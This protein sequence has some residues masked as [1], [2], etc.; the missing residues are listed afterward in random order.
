V[1]DVGET[2]DA[3]VR[4]LLAATGGFAPR[5]ADAGDVLLTVDG[6]PFQPRPIDPHLAAGSLAWL[7]DV[8]VLAHEYLGD[9]IRRR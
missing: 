8:A 3:A 7:S 5:L 6:E 4:D 1:L 9:G 2:N